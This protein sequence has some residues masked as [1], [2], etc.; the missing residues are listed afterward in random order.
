MK[1][2]DH[3]RLREPIHG[4]DFFDNGQ[5]RALPAGTEGT[6]VELLDHGR[7]LVVEFTTA[8]PSF[9]PQGDLADP[10]EIH[11]AALTPDQVE[12]AA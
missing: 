1:L 2:F 6:V 11:V 5:V 3:I 12:A 7:T 4:P 8:E 10:G 9:T